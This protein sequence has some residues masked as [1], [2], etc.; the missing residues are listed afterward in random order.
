MDT[1][2]LTAATATDEQ[3]HNLCVRAGEHGDMDMVRVCR[4]TIDG[5]KAARKECAKVLNGAAAMM[6]GE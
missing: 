5:S 2:T 3:I 6:D 4:R 1:T